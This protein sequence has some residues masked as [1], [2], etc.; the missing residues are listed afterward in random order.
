MS[1]PTDVKPTESPPLVMASRRSRSSS[2][3]VDIVRRPMRAGRLGIVVVANGRS[4]V[5]LADDVPVGSVAG[6]L[7][8]L[9]DDHPESVDGFAF[10]G[11]PECRRAL[12]FR[13]AHA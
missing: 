11:M 5:A 8:H 9:L 2:R 7:R 12:V 4:A 1:A 3:T 13:P 10:C 6:A